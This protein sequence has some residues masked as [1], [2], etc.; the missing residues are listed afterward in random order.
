MFAG[1]MNPAFRQIG[2]AVPPL[3]AKVIAQA[4]L[5]TLRACV[6][7]ESRLLVVAGGKR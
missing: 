6:E 5:K 1:T 2:N 7:E 4:A 3:L